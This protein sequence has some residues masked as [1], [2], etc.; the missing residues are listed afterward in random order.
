MIVPDDRQRS[1]RAIFTAVE[2]PV[3]PPLAAGIL[4]IGPQDVPTGFEY[5]ELQ[6]L[7]I[8]RHE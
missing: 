8:L 1:C 5:P 4:R 6:W 2:N 3:N 7:P